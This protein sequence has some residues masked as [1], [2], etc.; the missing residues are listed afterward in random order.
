MP[1]D[2]KTALRLASATQ[3]FVRKKRCVSGV[4]RLRQ[5]DSGDSQ[6]AHRLTRPG[7][8][9]A[10]LFRAFAAPIQRRIASIAAVTA[11]MGCMPSTD[12][13]MPRAA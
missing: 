8:V 7:G 12:F 2:K 11:S 5:P 13:T 10:S 9:S 3:P 1:G 4:E 6:T